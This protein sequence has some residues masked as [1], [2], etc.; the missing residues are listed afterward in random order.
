MF[1]L[2][3]H[4]YCAFMGLRL[5]QNLPFTLALLLIPYLCSSV[6]L[7]TTI[8]KG[9]E[10]TLSYRSALM[11]STCIESLMKI[12]LMIDGSSDY[13]M[14]GGELQVFCYING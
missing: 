7:R 10:Y 11:Q 5:F 6:L 14:A 4:V 2:R 12:A 9:N 3:L 8:C 1:S 13:V